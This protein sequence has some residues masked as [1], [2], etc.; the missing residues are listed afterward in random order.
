MVGHI[1]TLICSAGPG[2]RQRRPTVITMRRTPLPIGLRRRLDALVT[3]HP[4]ADIAEA[5][6][7]LRHLVDA[8]GPQTS[9]AA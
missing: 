2:T 6:A 1:D 8:L 5:A 4:H 7:E 9:Q 3:E